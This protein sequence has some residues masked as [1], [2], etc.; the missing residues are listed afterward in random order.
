MEWKHVMSDIHFSKSHMRMIYSRAHY[1]TFRSISIQFIPFQS[2]PVQSIPFHSN[3][4]QVDEIHSIPFHPIPIQSNLI[5]MEWNE[6]MSWVTYISANHIWEWSI[7]EPITLH[8]DPFQ[9]NSFH[10][11]PIQSNPFH[12]IPIQAKSMKSIPFHSIPSHSNPI[13]SNPIKSNPIPS[14][15]RIV[16]RFSGKI[17]FYAFWMAKC[18]SKCIKLYFSQEK[19]MCAFLDPFPRNTHIRSL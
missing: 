8:S 7:Q 14:K 15:P 6:N 4:S 18:L 3:P 1:I 9:S 19:N 5:W 16:F 11:N 2:N 13:Q 12:S 17:S 10:S